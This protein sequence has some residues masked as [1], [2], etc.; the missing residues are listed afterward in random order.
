MFYCSS[1]GIFT[2]LL[3]IL[4]DLSPGTGGLNLL[5]LTSGSE[6]PITAAAAAAG[7]GC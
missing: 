3:Y 7:M 1:V 6:C 2:Y 4:G 5:Y